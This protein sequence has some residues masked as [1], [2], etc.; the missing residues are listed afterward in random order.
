LLPAID[1]IARRLDALARRHARVA[2]LART[3]G[4]P[5]SPTTLGK[6]MANFAHRLK[7]ARGKVAAVQ[8]L[9]KLNG[10]TGGFNAHVAA[11]PAVDW[12]RVAE[13]FVASLG[14]AYNPLT[15]Q[16]EPHDALAEA[17]DAFARVNTILIGLDRDLWGYISLG[18]FRQKA[19]P[20]EVG[21]STM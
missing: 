19:K 1:G 14:L 10:A 12:P 11:A 2:M 13:R 21:S 5:A 3:H 15:T 9:G 4:Q 8:M 16:I 20:G 7:R 17:F 6:E 18:Y